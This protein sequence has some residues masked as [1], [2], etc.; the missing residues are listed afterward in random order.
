MC[1]FN[2]TPVEQAKTDVDCPTTS[3][4]GYFEVFSRN[5]IRMVELV[6]SGVEAAD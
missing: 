5:R 2:W 6:M 4:E 1:K 3:T